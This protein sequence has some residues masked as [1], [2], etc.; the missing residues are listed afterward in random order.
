MSY[1]F[2]VIEVLPEIVGKPWN[3]ITQAYLRALRPSS[4]RMVVD[5]EAIT[6]DAKLWRVTVF[7]EA[8]SAPRL[9]RHVEQEVEVDLP[10]GVDH[11]HALHCRMMD[12]KP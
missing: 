8:M 5:G 10:P 3:E 12:L 9:V 4:V 7:L 1:G 11:G 2:S 6:S